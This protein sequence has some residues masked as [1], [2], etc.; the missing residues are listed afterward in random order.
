MSR[1]IKNL[2]NT[3]TKFICMYF[4][5]FLF[6]Q[7][8]KAKLL[9]ETQNGKRQQSDTTEGVKAEGTEGLIWEVNIFKENKKL[10]WGDA[11]V[12]AHR[13]SWTLLEDKNKDWTPAGQY[14][15]KKAEC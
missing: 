9:N 4:L 14:K 5:F 6:W 8:Q 7:L 3:D 1:F 2:M 10:L 15:L 11:H 13:K 12:W